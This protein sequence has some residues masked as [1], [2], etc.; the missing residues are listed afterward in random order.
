MPLNQDTR[1][2]AIETPLGAGVL[3]IREVT[4]HEELGRLFRMDVE[5]SSEDAA[6]DFDQIVGQNVTIRLTID[7]A[8]PRYFNGFVSRFVQL[9]NKGKLAQY[10]AEVV[11]WMWFLTRTSDCRIFQEK[12]APEIIEE[13]FQAHGFNDYELSLSASYEKREYCVQYRE[14]DFNFVSRLMEEEGI[15]YFFRH[16]NG[17]HIAV[18]ADS[19]SAHTPF[20]GFK[21]V[22]FNPIDQAGA[23]RVAIHE[24]TVEREVQPVAY[25]TSDFNFLTPKTSLLASSSVTRQHGGASFE[26]FE[27]PG[28]YK[29]HAEGSA[30]SDIRIQEIQTKFE[31]FRGQTTT[32][33]GLATGSLFN[34]AS[35]PAAAMNREYLVTGT[36]IRVEEGEF[37]TGRKGGK[38]PFF[39][40]AV[41]AIASQQTFRAAR[42]TPRPF[43]Q[44]VQTAIVVGPAGE[45]IHTDKHGRI[46]VQFHWDRR[47]KFDDNSSCWMR[48]SQPSAGKGWGSMIIPR[49]GQEVIVDF[50]EGDPDRPIV[51]G[52]VYNAD[53]APPYA[54]GKGV[55]SGLKS[56][57]HKGAGFNEISMDD[58]AGKEKVFIHAQYD[59]HMRA[60]HDRVENVANDHHCTI[61]N[62]S[63]QSVAANQSLSVGADQ[64][65]S[66][67]ANAGVS[68]GGK[69]AVS[70][71][72]TDSRDVGGAV[73]EKCGGARSMAV[74]GKLLINAPDILVDASGNITLKAGGTEI[75]LGAG[76]VKIA[77][78][79]DVKITAGGKIEVSAG[80]K[81]ELAGGGPVDIKGPKI[82]AA[83]DAAAVFK[84]ATVTVEGSGKVDVKSGGPATVKGAVVQ[85]N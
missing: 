74:G 67:G 34:L 80:S 29:T 17:K 20:P 11:P 73:M 40:C 7:G 65:V 75:V 70:I 35:H 61:A 30:R 47:G 51:T 27:F 83:A 53:Q 9:P 33:R 64:K 19:T 32:V 56:N 18:L 78:A 77:T 76:G 38:E 13:V 10:R 81:V 45:E 3:A 28:E 82:T 1:L 12:T 66:V 36:A 50:I 60:G 25:A 84:G 41:V 39:A 52:R 6:V 26:I 59:M 15:C 43:V 31:T 54:A 46:K 48:V 14:T 57:T 8:G 49:I 5:L 24:W 2:L 68:I 62:N 16:E 55:V 42:T 63:S 71:G 22:M 21:D 23:A 72:G 79:G 37:E 85:V 44:G 58:T 4:I 69:S